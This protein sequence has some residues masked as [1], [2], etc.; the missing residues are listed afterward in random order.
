MSRIHT[1][2]ETAAERSRRFTEELDGVDR[3]TEPELR[4][5]IDKL[6]DRA[7]FLGVVART[8]KWKSARHCSKCPY[9]AGCIVCDLP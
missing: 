8:V 2:G 1:I 3:M 7:D 5:E 4:R 6:A 9:P